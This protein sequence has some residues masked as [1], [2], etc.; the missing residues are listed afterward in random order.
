MFLLPINVWA[1]L[2]SALASMALGFLWYSPALFGKQWMKLSKID[3]KK[4]K[5]ANK[6]MTKMYSISFISTL[7]G[8]YI[9]AQLIDLTLTSSVMEGAT[10]GAMVWLGFV[11]VTLVNTVVFES[12][13]WTLFLI[14]SGYQLVC[15]VV[16]GI[17]LAVWI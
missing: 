13:P 5:E 12:K 11:A 1:V 6:H 9:L 14:N 10:L 16:S 7:I 17:I 15:L 4:M 3:P 8:A 2:V